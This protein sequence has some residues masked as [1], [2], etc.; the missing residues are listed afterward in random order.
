[1]ACDSPN[2]I[3]PHL[4]TTL[5]RILYLALFYPTLYSRLP[6]RYR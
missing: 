6:Y 5:Y 1:M 2:I 3:K 4:S